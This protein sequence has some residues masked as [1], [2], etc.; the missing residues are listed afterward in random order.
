MDVLK[1]HQLSVMRRQKLTLGTSLA[2]AHGYHQSGHPYTR[3]FLALQLLENAKVIAMSVE[4]E[5]WDSL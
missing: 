1:A 3:C 2:T 4:Q 5:V